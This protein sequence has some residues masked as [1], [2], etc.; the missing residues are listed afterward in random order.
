MK[1]LLSLILAVVLI[2]LGAVT[3]SAESI[4]KFNVNLISET[5]KEAVISI[6]FEG[7]TAFCALDIE[8]KFDDTRV[9]I[10]KAEKGAGLNAFTEKEGTSFALINKDINPVKAT[11]VSLSPFRVVD[12]KDLFVITVKKLSKE[13]L[14]SDDFEVIVTNCADSSERNITP[15]VTT[16]LQG[17]AKTEL[18]TTTTTAPSST[19]EVSDATDEPT[20]TNAVEPDT[21]TI[22]VED[23]SENLPDEKNDEPQD[24]PNTVVIIAGVGVF[25]A[26]AAAVVAVVSVK[27]KKSPIPQDETKTEE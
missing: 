24:K 14:S 4:A 8:I 9:K 15:S 20:Y 13:A 7:G 12:G 2:A 3:A 11:M 23:T 10:S 16:D 25:L 19:S 21:E 17:E 22:D 27:K 1:K 26:V 18:S 5:A 6:D